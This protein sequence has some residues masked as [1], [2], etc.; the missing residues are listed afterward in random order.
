MTEITGII[1][2]L[3]PQ[4]GNY[5]VLRIPA[6]VVAS[7]PKK[8]STRLQCTLE[9]GLQFD[10]GLNHMG[11][12]DYFVILSKRNLKSLR[13]EPGERITFEIIEHPLPLGVEIPK[14]LEVL[15]EQDAEAMDLWKRITDGRKRT[16]VFAIKRIKDIDKQIHTALKLVHE[17]KTK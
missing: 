14:V 16:I 17:S 12:G 9:N 10:C 2:Q 4:K 15:L 1:E 11:D 3:T 6:K 7:F 5:T 8:R 13:K